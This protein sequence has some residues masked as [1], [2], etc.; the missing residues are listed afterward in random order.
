MK[1]NLL[2]ALI[3]ASA[4]ATAPSAASA[5]K[6]CYGL[7]IG[8]D[9]TAED[10]Q[11]SADLYGRAP[12]G[13]LLFYDSRSLPNLG[14]LKAIANTQTTPFITIEPWNAETKEF[15]A[16]SDE[17]V[18]SLALVISEFGDTVAVRF[19]HEMNG[20]WYPWAGNPDEYKKLYVDFHQRLSQAAPNANI[21]WI[22]SVNA[23]D[24]PE[25]N[26]AMDY[27]PGDEYVDLI[28]LDGY[29]KNPPWFV[30]AYIYLKA[31]LTQKGAFDYIFAE[32]M[33]RLA[34]LGKPFMVTETA[35]ASTEDFKPYAIQTF[36]KDLERN[37][38][39]FSFIWFDVQKEAN[40]RIASDIKSLDTFQRVIKKWMPYEKK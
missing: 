18:N 27:Y 30:R 36:F 28:G 24:V 39:I 32:Q 29:L 4:I 26:L 11:K 33:E 35:I 22:W 31:K 16:P 17:Y 6:H 1:K 14:E 12:C 8:N 37:G 23:P 34:V 5:A 7:F 25:N 38:K 21:L 10:I 3:L 2:K 13:I 20:D 40:W 9:V 19:A 15:V